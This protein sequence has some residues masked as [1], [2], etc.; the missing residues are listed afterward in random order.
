MSTADHSAGNNK[1]FFSGVTGNINQLALGAVNEVVTSQGPTSSPTFEPL[2]LTKGAID[3]FRLL[4]DT[5]V[6]VDIEPGEASDSTNVFNLVSL[7]TINV[8]RFAV[9]GPGGRQTGTTINPDTWQKILIIGDT[10]GVNAIDGLMVPVGT[11][12]SEAG[13]DVFRR[14]GYVRM[15]SGTDIIFFG[16][17]GI[18]KYR[19]ILWQAIHTQ[20][21][22]LSGGSATSRTAVDCSSLIPPTSETAYLLLEQ[23]ASPNVDF[24]IAA[25]GNIILQLARD[26]TVTPL[27]NVSP[28]QEIFY[29]NAN[30]GG[31][32]DIGVRGYVDEI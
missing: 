27:I 22:V 14:V 4:F 5:N 31:S 12:F 19:S 24:A 3:G 9:E 11:A 28:T 2:P 23:N 18:G 7:A 20:L 30:P 29:V 15:N 17:A 32:V 16:A 26:E 6:A 13:Y 8:D 21:I 1:V 25:L 10:T